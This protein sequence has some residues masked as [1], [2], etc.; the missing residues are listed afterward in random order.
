MDKT[1]DKTKDNLIYALA[2]LVSVGFIITWLMLASPG[3]ITKCEE[4][5]GAELIMENSSTI[6]AG[7]NIPNAGYFVFTNGRDFEQINK[8][9]YH[10]ACHELVRHD[11][12][13]FCEEYYKEE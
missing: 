13:H 11:Y 7:L 1:M 8:T 10:E 3:Y 12:Y 6:I 9:D 5:K 2:L 4:N